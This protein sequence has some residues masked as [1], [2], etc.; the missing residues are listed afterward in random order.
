MGIYF[1]TI[2][3]C[4]CQHGCVRL[5]LVLQVYNTILKIVF[6]STSFATIY[7]MKY[8]Y[9]KS[10][11]VQNDTFRMIFLVVPSFVL[12]CFINYYPNPQEVRLAH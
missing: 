8:T 4:C 12:A 3:V 6:L 5:T 10:Y 1:G 11:D 2:I 7:L 9:N